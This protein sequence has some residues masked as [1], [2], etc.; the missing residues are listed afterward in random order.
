MEAVE[1]TNLEAAIGWLTDTILSNLPAGGKLDS[2]IG[3]AG[4]GNDIG[5]LKSEVEAV[6]MVVSAVQGRAAGNKPLAR[7]LAAVKE[8]LYDADD[9]VDELDCYRLQQELEPDTLLETDGHRTQQVERSRENAD[10]QSSSNG[11]GRLRSKEWNHFDITQFEQNGGPARARCKYCETEVMCTTKKGTSVLRNHLNSKGCSKKREATDPSSSIV[12]AT[13]IHV[14]VATG[15]SSNRKRMRTGQEST[16]IN[17][18]NPNGWNKDSFPKR[19]QDITSQLQGK[20]EAVT[21]I[22]KILGSDSGG[23]TSN[24]SQLMVTD[25]RRRTSSL[26][27]G[28]VYGRAEDKSYIKML[29]KECKSDASLTVLPI[30]GIGGVGKTTL[31]QLVYNDPALKSQFDHKIWIWVSNNFDEM[32]LT[33]QMLEC[34][35]QESHDG[36]CSFPN[37][38]EILKGHIKSKRFLLVLDDVWKDMDDGRWNKLLAPFNSGSA[39]GNMIIMTTRKLS[40]AKRRGTIRPI[41]LGT[42]GK[43]H[44]WQLFKSCAFGDENYEAQASLSDLGQEIAQKLKGNPLAAQTAGA[45]LRDHLTVDHWSNTLKTEAWNSLQRADG[46]MFC[47][48]LSYDELTYPLRQCCSYCSIFPYNYQF[49][50][51]ELVRLWISQGFVKCDHSSRSLE[52]IGWYYLTDLVNLGL[53]QR[54][55]IEKPSIGSQTYYIMCGLMYDFARLVSRTECA[56]LD[57]L[58]CNTVLSTVHHLS[59]VT[60]CIYRRDNKTGSIR[61]C[62]N[63]D[64][65]SQNIVASVRKLRTVVLIG[66]YD[67]FFFKEFQD[68][69]EKAHNLRLLQMSATSADF[70][71]F[72]RSLANPTRLRYLKLQN[73]HTEQK[74]LPQVLNKFFHLQVLDAAFCMSLHMVDLEDCSEQRI[75]P[76]LEML[77][78]LKRLKL[79]NMRRVSEVLVPSLEELVLDGMPDLQR[80]SCTSVGG[81]KSSLRVLEIQRCPVLDVFD[82]FQKG[83]NYETEHKSWLPSLRKLIMCDCPNLQVQ[84][85]LPLS[86]IFSELLI[87]R[88]STIM[89]MEGSSMGTFKSNGKRI[90]DMPFVQTMALDDRILAFHNLKDIKCLEISSCGNLTSISFKCLSQLISLKSLK[91][92]DCTKL[93]SPD[94]VP[95]HTHEDTITVKDAALPALESLDIRGCRIIGKCLSLMLQ[96]SPTLKD[97]YLY[98]CSQL[99]QQRIEEEGKVSASWTSRYLCDASSGYADDTRPYADDTR[100]SS[101]VE[102]LVHIPLDLKKITICGCPHL[103]VDGSREGFAGFTSSSQVENGRCLL[104]QSLEHLDWSD[105]SRKALRPCFVGNLTC[106]KKINLNSGRSLECLQ[107]DSCTALEDLEIQGCD[108]LVTIEGL[109]SLGILRSLKLSYNSRLKSLQLHSCTSLERLEVGSCSSL[110]TLEG[111]QSLVTLKHLEIIDSPALDSLATLQSYEPIEGISSHIHELFPALESLKVDDLSPLNTSFCKGLICLRSL[112]FISLDA[113]ILTDEQESVFLLLGSLQELQFIDSRHLLDLP[114][115]LSSLP[116]LKT[117]KIIGCKRILGLPKEGLPPSLKQLV[118]K[119][120]SFELKEQCRS[121]ATSKLEVLTTWIDF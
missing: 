102:D 15:N 54:V 73:G 9:V 2:W 87:S 68:V 94:S 48:K 3:Q 118:I 109:R 30:V 56:T 40:I 92:V 83:C 25:P 23:A 81:M 112:N 38:Q 110:V 114:S 33:R 61:R 37:L 72:M 64:F 14:P 93:F 45:L 96:H 52:E 19:I 97:L 63:F 12:D 82:L 67:S 62:E 65:L 74:A 66:E 32:R 20:R 75:L 18:A 113:T 42:L 24:H 35:S 100:P 60:D 79:C 69:F 36:L 21:R 117:L 46:I 78:F 90:W 27:Q 51:E 41:N 99:T 101:A 55:E 85:P 98:N 7:S 103:I 105:Y 31:A 8:L 39:N 43:D 116:S 57:G 34:V 111:L 89:T 4:L 120:C 115:G 22:L 70:S 71:S 26:V 91:I 11:N 86:A 106:L 5:K 119:Q 80:C 107:L 88:V 10:V 108:Q 121:L 13:T 58:Q 17:A 6:E 28:K 47:L 49:L 44:F 104:P 95:K 84:T 50:A 77:R 59:I 29:I 76:S 1:D 16:H 53:F